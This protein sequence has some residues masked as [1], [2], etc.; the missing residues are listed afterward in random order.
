M[1]RYGYPATDVV[2]AFVD[3]REAG[4][5]RA[6]VPGGRRVDA[7]H[8]YGPGGALH[9]YSYATIVAARRPRPHDGVV[10]IAVTTR[11][12]S[13]TTSKLMGRLRVALAAAGYEPTSDT[14]LVSAKVPGRWGGFGPAWAPSSH[15]DLMFQVW[16]QS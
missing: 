12:Y 15:E 16:R 6:P 14:A 11:R 13:V 4:T 3:G 8:T 10:E 7:A 9:L 1:K 2:R 5:V